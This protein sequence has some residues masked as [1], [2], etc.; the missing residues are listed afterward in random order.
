MRCLVTGANGFAASHLVE[1]LLAKGH[2]VIGTHRIRARL[3]NLYAVPHDSNFSFAV[4]ELS[5]PFGVEEIIRKHRPE[6]IFHLA[7]Q[8]FVGMS[9]TNPEETLKSNILGT[10]YVLEAARK[11]VPTA[12]IHIASSSQVYGAIPE[13]EQPM[14]KATRFNPMN[15]YDTSKLAQDMLALQY[16]NSYKMNIVRTR[17]FNISGPRRGDSFAESSWAK[18]IAQMEAHGGEQVIKHG[19]LESARDYIDVRDV[20][21]AYEWAGLEGKPGELYILGSGQGVKML[22]ILG[23]LTSLSPLHITTAEDP[24]R[25]RPSDTPYMRAGESDLARI[26]REKEGRDLI[27]LKQTL[28]DLLNYWRRRA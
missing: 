16:F 22:H 28:E 7:A 24:A 8:S 5:D 19:N 14:G 1:R 26:V 20:V 13:E 3:E 15:P 27:P 23:L 25:M 4:M 17:A 6:V 12:R 11:H 9:W 18:Q 10:L 21:V 2:E